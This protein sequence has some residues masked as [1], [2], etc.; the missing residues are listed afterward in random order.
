VRIAEIFTSIQGE[1]TRQ[2]LPTVFVR[3]GGCNLRCR[4]CDTTYAQT[5]GDEMSPDEIIARV[6]ASGLE[7]A[8]ITGG[9][10]LLQEETPALVERLLDLGMKPAVETNGTIDASA[11][12]D[13]CLRIIDIK[14]PGS[15]ES[16]K[17]HPAN[18]RAIRSMD[19]F[20]FVIGSRGDFEYARDFVRT[21]G[22]DGRCT[23][24]LSPVSGML[25]PAELA[26]WLIGECPAARLN[27]QLHKIIWPSDVRGR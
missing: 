25:A 11:L 12:P 15:G 21:N 6:S 2:G 8:C 24:L 7:Y 23:V 17:T 14:C 5:G 16:G 3:T 9:E 10:P 13:A 19:E 20:K 4:W 27:L 1:S 18:L 26:E 22:L